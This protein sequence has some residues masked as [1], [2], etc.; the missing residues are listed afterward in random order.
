MTTPGETERIIKS[1]VRINATLEERIEILKQ[2][3]SIQESTI[4]TY[5]DMVVRNAYITEIENRD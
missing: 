2:T 4:K 5:R 1:L 3:I